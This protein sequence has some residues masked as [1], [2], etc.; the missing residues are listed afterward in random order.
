[1]KLV[2]KIAKKILHTQQFFL[3]EQSF[4]VA[5]DFQPKLLVL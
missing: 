1:M 2:R 3:A 5:V 4:F